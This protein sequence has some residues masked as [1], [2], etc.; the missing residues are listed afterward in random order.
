[1]M[2]S[3]TPVT[4]AVGVENLQHIL[5]SCPSCLSSGLYTWHHNNVLKVVVDAVNERV[6]KANLANDSNGGLQFINFVTEGCL[7][8]SYVASAQSG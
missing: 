8:G 3:R 7:S 5:S 4:P 1:M 2:L 6:Q